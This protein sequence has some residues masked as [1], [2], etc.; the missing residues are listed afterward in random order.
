M[1]V[2]AP[3]QGLINLYKVYIQLDETME[4]VDQEYFKKP[5]LIGNNA[6]KDYGFI[7]EGTSYNKCKIQMVQLLETEAWAFA[8]DGDHLPA[9][10]QVPKWLR[11]RLSDS[12]RNVN[13]EA[14]QSPDKEWNKKTILEDFTVKMMEETIT[15]YQEYYEH[16]NAKSV[17]YSC[18]VAE[19]M[20]H[21]KNIENS[22][23]AKYRVLPALKP[24]IDTLDEYV[25]NKQ[26]EKLTSKLQLMETIG[27]P[28]SQYYNACYT[29]AKVMM[30]CEDDKQRSVL[31]HGIS[32]SGKSQIAKF[33]RDIFDSHY[34]K[35]TKSIYDEKISRQEAHKQIYI[36]DEANMV[37]LFRK[38]NVAD[39]KNLTSGQGIPL[40]NKY[41]HSFTGF[42]NSYTLM[43]CQYLVCPFIPPMSSLS[44]YNTYEYE[45]DK[46]AMLSRMRLV[47]FDKL[48]RDSGL[49]FGQDDWAL[50]LLYISDNFYDMP[51]PIQP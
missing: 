38:K 37:K 3:V 44:G 14:V 30:L 48:F 42:I 8:D 16:A 7:C 17:Q 24:M 51:A 45:H 31:F 47:K 33:M 21:L 32:D 35:E 22:E 39:M 10:M 15:G 18:K 27:G 4:P 2:A 25:E 20:S 13:L 5:N 23:K 43:T 26:L 40:E 28:N 12:F 36:V 19:F 41:N 6:L 34:K 46:M 29:I 11:D 49:V 9:H 1:I 50:C